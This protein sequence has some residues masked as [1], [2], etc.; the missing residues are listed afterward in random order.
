[1]ESNDNGLE[2]QCADCKEVFGG[3]ECKDCGGNM[4]VHTQP[5]NQQS[6]DAEDELEKIF[7]NTVPKIYP[8]ESSLK[9]QL[10]AFINSKA[11]ELLDELDEAN[12]ACV[13]SCEPD[14]DDLRHARHTGSWDHYTKMSSVIKEWRQRYE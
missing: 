12:F 7:V 11:L 1:M 3:Y 4:L 2:L 9:Q 8:W 5:T 6:D 13:E 14:C 10:Q